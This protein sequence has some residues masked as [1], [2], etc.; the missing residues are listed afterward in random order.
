MTASIFSKAY[1]AVATCTVSFTS[2][3]AVGA[4][5]VK[6]MLKDIHVFAAKLEGL[7]LPKFK[8]YH[9][10]KRVDN[11]YTY[12]VANMNCSLVCTFVIWECFWWKDT[13]IS[14]YDCRVMQGL[15]VI[16]ID[17]LLILVSSVPIFR[18]LMS[19]N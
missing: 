2:K 7:F 1:T 5:E 10:Q 17:S 9:I 16:H 12:T 19:N 15:C 11:E 4:H 6:E 13:N 18:G 3:Y 14:S 8:V